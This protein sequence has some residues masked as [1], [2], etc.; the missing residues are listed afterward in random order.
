MTD[1]A[2]A[3]VF[4]VAPDPE[5]EVD[6]IG[7]I[8]DEN[9]RNLLIIGE[10][11]A[12]VLGRYGDGWALN[13]AHRCGV[14][15]VQTVY[16]WRDGWEMMDY[17]RVVLLNTLG[18][19]NFSCL[20]TT[21]W[22]V[23]ARARRKYALNDAKCLEH[24]SAL[25]QCRERGELWG[26]RI[27]EAEIEAEH[28]KDKKAATWE[29]YHKP[30]LISQITDYLSLPQLPKSWRKWFMLAPERQSFDGKKTPAQRL[31]EKR[32]K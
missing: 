14:S 20:S 22:Q 19:W 1:T 26:S 11:V 32:M 2:P 13:I 5:S 25:M 17:F 29:G 8:H 23:I 28:G 24:L 7:A 21:H 6:E 12:G 10:K 16:N 15:S 4:T 30:R 3:T 18:A 31:A 27:L 9:Q